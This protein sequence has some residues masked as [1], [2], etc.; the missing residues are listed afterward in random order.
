M[1]VKETFEAATT[2]SEIPTATEGADAD[3]TGEEFTAEVEAAAEKLE[4]AVAAGE[5]G[6]F[7]ADLRETSLPFIPCTL[8]DKPRLIF[9][10]A[11]EVVRR[12]ASI[13]PAVALAVENHLF[14]VAAL[15]T[16]PLNEGEE[17]HRRRTEFV[18]MV[19][20]DR[21][22][23]ANTNSRVHGDKIASTGTR[24]VD[25]DGGFIVSG[26]SAYMSLASHGDLI[27]FLT[28]LEG[29]EAAIFTSQ[30]KGN[31]GI[32][33]GPFLFPDAMI[34]SDTRRVTFHDLRVPRDH[35]LVSGRDHH[36]MAAIVGFETGWHQGLLGALGLG[37][38]TRAL[39]E[40]RLFLRGLKQPDG[41]PLS[42]LDG[43]ITDMGRLTIR[44][45]AAEAF[46]TQAGEWIAGVAEQ[47]VLDRAYAQE[48]VD[49]ACAAKHFCTN[50]A[51]ELVAQVRK[52]IGARSFA[53]GHPM[54]RISQE[55]MF[56]PLAGEV[57]A[58]IER[59]VGQRT[60]GETSLLATR[61]PKRKVRVKTAR[62]EGLRARALAKKASRAQD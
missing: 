18:D 3:P 45:Q 61:S 21:C 51:E 50:T 16:L 6:R 40:G 30:L 34:D 14:V 53:G 47:P 22:L 57:N 28:E 2:A 26:R 24:A 55:G 54:E 31:P 11:A 12:F 8:R 59:R 37:V 56:A 25:C 9:D 36:N 49:R 32:E 27:V 29:G 10:R 1:P 19:E 4:A 15:A 62:L 43:M 44:Y 60:L 17:L 46:L 20:K 35:L 23:V 39:E 58:F 33:I 48:A 41:A 7:F 52:I 42:E 5:P 38:A 13:S